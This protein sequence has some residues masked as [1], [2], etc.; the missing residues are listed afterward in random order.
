MSHLYYDIRD[1]W[2]VN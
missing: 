1:T 2:I